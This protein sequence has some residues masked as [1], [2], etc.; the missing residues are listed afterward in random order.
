MN[1]TLY[2]DTMFVNKMPF[3]VTISKNI[4]Y[5]TADYVSDKKIPTYHKALDRVFGIY[6]NA[7]FSIAV[8]SS[9]PEFQ[10]VLDP[11]KGVLQFKTN[12]ASANEHVPPIEHN[13][14]TLK[15]RVRSV[16]H[17]LPYRAIP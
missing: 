9:D 6:N 4:K 5:Q 15:E 3:M 8:I 1:I 10:P 11:I 12:Y 2:L 13:N 14:R 7:G 17:A 16:F